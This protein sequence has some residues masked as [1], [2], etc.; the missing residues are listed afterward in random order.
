[1]TFIKFVETSDTVFIITIFFS[2]FISYA[3]FE[4]CCEEQHL[5]Y[6]NLGQWNLLLSYENHSL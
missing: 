5:F 6:Y 1:M 3:F 2:F 4:Y